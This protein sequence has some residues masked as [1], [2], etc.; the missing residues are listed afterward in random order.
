MP[1]IVYYYN[2]EIILP[3]VSLSSCA[4]QRQIDAG[5]T[6]ATLSA[7]SVD[8]TLHAARCWIEA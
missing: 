4:W 7:A 6:C 8:A 2:V 1:N 3:A 5:W